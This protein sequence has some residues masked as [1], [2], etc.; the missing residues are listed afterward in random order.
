MSAF[1]T[2]RARVEGH[3]SA[4]LLLACGLGL[5]LPGLGDLPNETA[6][7]TLAA[8][9]FLSFFS[10]REG[11]WKSLHWPSL[12]VY[13]VLR[14]GVTPWLL[15]LA[16]RPFS[17]DYAVGVFLLGTLPAAVSSPAIA[18]IYGGA[19]APAFVIVIV[20]QLATPFLVPGQFALL[21]GAGAG[22]GEAVIPNPFDLFHTMAWCIFLPAALYL[23]LRKNAA[24][25][26]HVQC[27]GKLWAMGLV[28]FVI[29]L[30]VAKQREAILAQGFGLVTLLG[31]NALCYVLFIALGWACAKGRTQEARVTYAVCSGFNNAALGVSLA[32]LHFPAPI[33]LFVAVSEIAWSLQ[34]MLFG[35]FFR[36]KPR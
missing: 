15:W 21:A 24:M 16:V 30:V 27:N 18:N 19:I 14:Y 34:P 17:P 12:C 13:Y 1:A 2:F 31:L 25:S 6:I 10:L 23:P 36:R 22:V 20:S 28:A 33:V 29:A 35:L 26:G 9:M 11:E 4:M 32:L 5:V 7:A 3:F 8:L